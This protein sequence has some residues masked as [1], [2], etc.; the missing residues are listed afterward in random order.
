VLVVAVQ[1]MML[2]MPSHFAGFPN[3]TVD[4]EVLGGQPT[5]RGMRISVRRVLEA[6][7]RRPDWAEFTLDYPDITREDVRQALAFAASMSDARVIP[8]E[9]RSA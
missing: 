7:S 4:P 3:I 1:A 8:I 9:R 6:L 5:I 2:G